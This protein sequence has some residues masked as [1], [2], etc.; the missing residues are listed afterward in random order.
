MSRTDAGWTVKEQQMFVSSG[1]GFRGDADDACVALMDR[2][3]GD[4]SVR[5]V[6][7]D[8]ARMSG[9]SLD[10]GMILRVIRG[11]V[12]QGHLIPGS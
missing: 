4:R 6:L 12:E 3:R 9:Q 2:C 5:E 8:L 10:Q 11:L 7:D 1:L